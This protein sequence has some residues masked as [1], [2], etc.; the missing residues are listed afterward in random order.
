MNRQ[1]EDVELGM[2]RCITVDMLRAL[3]EDYKISSQYLISGEIG[4]FQMQKIM[5]LECLKF[6]DENNIN[7]FKISEWKE[8]IGSPD[9]DLYEYDNLLLYFAMNLSGVV[10]HYSYKDKK[11][12]FLDAVKAAVYDK[13]K[14]QNFRGKTD[15]FTEFGAVFIADKLGHIVMEDSSILPAFIAFLLIEIS[16]VGIEA[17]CKYYEETVKAEK[18]ECK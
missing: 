15:L 7:P 6:L 13:V 8:M 14:D 2:R 10:V 3:H 18:D 11:P 17:W 1:K 12:E 16:K 5:I 4:G 9:I